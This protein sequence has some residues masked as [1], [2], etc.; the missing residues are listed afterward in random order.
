MVAPALHHSLCENCAFILKV[1][2]CFVVRQ[3]R[4]PVVIFYM[5][6]K[7]ESVVYFADND[8]HELFSGTLHLGLEVYCE[9]VKRIVGY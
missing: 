3:L 5:T 6:P 1:E 9:D 4:V 7:H 2:F 8:L